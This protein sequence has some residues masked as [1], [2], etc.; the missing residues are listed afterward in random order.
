MHDVVPPRKALINHVYTA[1]CGRILFQD[2]DFSLEPYLSLVGAAQ[3]ANATQLNNILT[4]IKDGSGVAV[5]KGPLGTPGDFVTGASSNS[6]AERL[7]EDLVTNNISVET[8]FNVWAATIQRAAL[9][10]PATSGESGVSLYHEFKLLSALVHASNAATEPAAAFLLVSGDFPG[11]QR[12]I[13]SITSEGATKGV[14]GR[15]FFLQLLGEC[16]VRRLVTP[17]PTTNV[18]YL[19]GG[20]FQL[21]LPVAEAKTVRSATQQI[22]EQMLE[23]FHGDLALVTATVE[24]NHAD[25]R[26]SDRMSQQSRLL[27]AR[28]SQARMRPFA[29]FAGSA[30]FEAT[31]S[32]E[33]Y[34]CAISRREPLSPDELR[35]A[36]KAEENDEPWISPEQQAF[37]GLAEDLA[38][39]SKPNSS[40]YLRYMTEINAEQDPDY[41][42]ILHR[43]TGIGCCI[44]EA[45]E[46]KQ[47]SG[48]F[49]RLNDTDFDPG[50]SDGFR[51][52]AVHTPLVQE[53]DIEWFRYEGRFEE[54]NA[55]TQNQSI[56]DFE[57]L[58]TQGGEAEFARLGVLRMDVDS[59]GELF[60][61]HLPDRTLTRYMA[62]SDAMSLF[63]DGYLPVIC[64]EL[65]TELKRQDSLYLIYGGGDDLFIVGE[66]DLLPRLAKNIRDAFKNYTDSRLSISAGIVLVPVK[67]PFYRAAEMAKEALDD[68]AKKLPGK[69][70][71]CFLDTVVAWE[72]D[73]NLNWGVVE[74]Q[75]NRLLAIS[76]VLGSDTVTRNVLRIFELWQADQREYAADD[77]IRFGPHK[78]RGLYQLSQV[79]GQY[80]ENIAHNIEIIQN[81]LLD[82]DKIKLFGVAA[83]WAEFKQR[84][85][86]KQGEVQI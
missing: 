9:S 21:L 20:N 60:S 8:R 48:S 69:D 31:G 41:T 84:V 80:G 11:V 32:G 28:E 49:L 59:L 39:A 76:N 22:N 53:K 72:S 66:W 24:I 51:F 58:A 7:L 38:S 40:P 44:V 6:N 82:T 29:D 18:I 64:K 50:V 5:P 63:F 43:L 86:S 70:A 57:L 3:P 12:T 46:T 15:S 73:P 79:K 74:N 14:R 54:A 17:M 13:Y 36:E 78:W 75:Y 45:Q 2:T 56:R 71:I 34:F 61:T 26:D 4:T 30:L 68:K 23:I 52:L 42:K 33:K 62:A 47:Q 16:V 67:F 35:A 85:N 77:T 10:T 27:K 1:L 25:L 65:E 55:L 19:A 81:W 83:R 37:R